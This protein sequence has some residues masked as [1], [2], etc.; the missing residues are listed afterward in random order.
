MTSEPKYPV[1]DL[2]WVYHAC[3]ADESLPPG[4][5]RWHDFSALRGGN[6]LT[7]LG[8]VLKSHTIPGKFHHRI[9]CGHR[10][11]GKS[12][13]LRSL[14]K[15]ADE[16]G[17]LTIWIEVD[18]YFGLAALQ[19]SD[20]YLLAAE[21]VAKAMD[22][23]GSS[24]PADKLEKVVQWF[25]KVTKESLE[26]LRSELKI[27]TGAKLSSVFSLLLGGLFANF[28][29]G[30]KA[31]SEHHSNVRIEMRQAPN[32]L[33]DLTNDL[34]RAAHQQ[35]QKKGRPHGLLLLFDNL[36]RFEPE[37]IKTLLLEGSTLIRELNCHA[38]FTMP[39]NLHYGPDSPYQDSY[40][41]PATILPMLALRPPDA[42]W[43]ETVDK[44]PFQRKAVDEMV[45]ALN[46]RI[47]VKT[48]FSKPADARLLVK[49]SGGCIR[50]LLHLV[51]LAYQ[52]SFTSL[53]APVKHLTSRGVRRAIE[54]YRGY[55]TAGLLADNYERLAA[56]ARRDPG[57]QA[58]D[59]PMLQLLKRRIAFRYSNGK[60]QWLDVHPLVIETE[61]FQRAFASP[62]RVS[63][64]A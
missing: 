64:T 35:L 44:S 13:E 40:G 12:T 30:V 2:E 25:A 52:K 50:E 24:L 43:T 37:A 1:K 46:R 47:E 29:A 21:S 19:F 42:A 45:K 41:G 32:V 53:D 49:M 6:V 22:E 16:N 55:Q 51:N 58:L 38:V 34:L 15:W 54:E 63:T 59:A 14:K 57:S 23:S 56:V 39:I 7:D 5:P 36:D 20:L 18:L 33:I 27:E 11:C 60:E 4:D 9:L 17:F 8:V 48:L 61:G 62:P 10:G 26:D 31:G 28:S 3:S